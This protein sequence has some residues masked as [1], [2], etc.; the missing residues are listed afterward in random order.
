MSSD[1]KYVTFIDYVAATD[2]VDVSNANTPGVIDPTNPVPGAYYRAAAQLSQ[3]GKFTFTSINAYSGN[4]GRAAVEAK[5]KGKHYIYTAGNAGNGKNPQP[6]G[7]VLGAG[8]QIITPSNLPL[9]KQNPGQPTPVGSFNVTQLAT[10]RTR[11]ARTTTT[12]AWC[13]TTTCCTTP[14]AAA[15]T[16]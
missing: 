4:N 9:S 12:V 10:A 13:S 15:A 5:I 6:K 3:N 7:V 14:R 11:S 2:T 1:G 16:A 8:A